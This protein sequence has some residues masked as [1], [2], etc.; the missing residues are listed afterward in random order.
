MQRAADD[1]LQLGSA[2]LAAVDCT[3]IAGTSSPVGSDSQPTKRATPAIVNAAAAVRTDHRSRMRF[4]SQGDLSIS[5]SMADSDAA[6]VLL[7]NPE[8]ATEQDPLVR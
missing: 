2:R 1:V 5:P 4:S 7:A 8:G 3:M 6:E